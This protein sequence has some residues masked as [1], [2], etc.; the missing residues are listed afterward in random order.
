VKAENVIANPVKIG[1][2]KKK[3]NRARL[4]P[5]GFSVARSLYELTEP[6]I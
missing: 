1:G 4:S 5:P 3:I 2:K 6:K